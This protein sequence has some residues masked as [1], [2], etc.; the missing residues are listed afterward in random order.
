[1]TKSHIQSGGGKP[2][3]DLDGLVRELVVSEAEDSLWGTQFRQFLKQREKKDLE[4]ALDFV[5]LSAQL[6]IVQ[7]QA[8]LVFLFYFCNELVSSKFYSLLMDIETINLREMNI[9]MKFPAEVLTFQDDREQNQAARFERKKSRSTQ[10]DGTE[11]FQSWE[12]SLL[13]SLKS[14]E[15]FFCWRWILLQF[16]P[17]H[18]TLI[19]NISGAN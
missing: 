17:S 11:I 9:L 19:E 4:H 7:D 2:P 6:N 5:T 13:A 10:S 18:E 12:W 16:L 8:K 15:V 14:G 1:M 3:R